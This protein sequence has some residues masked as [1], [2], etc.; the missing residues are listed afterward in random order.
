MTGPDSNG[1]R[2]PPP[3]SGHGGT[4]QPSDDECTTL[5]AADGS[6]GTHHTNNHTQITREHRHQHHHH[7]DANESDLLLARTTSASSPSALAPELL[8]PT[9]LRGRQFS[10]SSARR[11]LLSPTPGSVKSDHGSAIG[12]AESADG[13]HRHT[14]NGNA[15]AA[16]T[17][18]EE[19]APTSTA[20][21]SSPSL[22]R[23]FL[24]DTDPKLFRVIFGGVL[25]VYFI[26]NF[27]GT[28]MA[29]S[30]PVITSYFR[31]SNQA[32]W[33]STAFLLTSTA[34][35]PIVGRLSDTI[36]RKPPYLFAMAIFLLATVWCA[37]AGSMTSFIIARAVCGLGAGGMISMGS[38]VVSDMVNIE[39]RGTYQSFINIT[40]G[41]ASASGAALGGVMADTMG[42]RWEFG[43]QVFP[44]V[45]CFALAACTMPADLGLYV[46]RETFV[47]AVKA[48]DWPG[49]VLLTGSTMFL[50]LGLNL[51]GNVL[52]WSHPFI[53]ASLVM[54]AIL[55]PTCLYAESRARRPIM[56]LKLLR[57]SPRA[58]MVFANFVASFL[59]NAVLFNAPLY[60]QAVLLMTATASGLRLIVP[61]AVAATFG[62]L[63]GFLITRT[64][65]LKWP[66]TLGS[67][68]Y[69]LGTVSLAS[70]GR[71]WPWW[72]YLLILAP[73]AMGQGFQFPG[74]FIAVLR[75]SAQAEQAVVTSTL[76]LWRAL[77]NVMGVAGSS[78]ILQNALL[79]YLRDYVVSDGTSQGDE[80]KLRLIA[81]V[82][83]SVEA[84]AALEDPVVR[85]QV[86]RSYEAALRMTFIC[87]IGLALVNM[88]LLLPVKLPR[89]GT[90]KQ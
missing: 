28:I 36:G 53:I 25:L 62:T 45:G 46:E 74:T 71:G 23:E 67:I 66:L 50:I 64:Q 42:W 15:G 1:N 47:E 9:M 89:L 22:S 63:T 69:V 14:V 34:V 88:A 60:F 37:L 3:W 75:V 54:F 2:N 27:D 41:L 86:V 73:S 72:A 30:H 59:L 49:T 24:I 68:G 17:I 70:L 20:P 65:R 81:K 19:A 79:H 4:D 31:S 85:E 43:V 52:P 12:D 18:D 21:A 7:L 10:D 16:G 29:S 82:R 77:G 38:I 78:L 40:Y 39:R 32:S 61:V 76:M 90:R 84:V 11:P 6:Y 58:N 51:G 44:L 87:C 80:A 57:S 13:I 8:E 35:Q 55:F 33:L 48:F 26:A 83:E 56:P 5:L